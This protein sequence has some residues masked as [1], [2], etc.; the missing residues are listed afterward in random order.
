VNHLL[1]DARRRVG[2]SEQRRGILIDTLD[3]IGH[4]LQ[5]RVPR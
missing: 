2:E 3:R 4:A 1:V 5:I